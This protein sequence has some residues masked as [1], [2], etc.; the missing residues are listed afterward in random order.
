MG[1]SN[2][3]ALLWFACI[4]LIPWQNRRMPTAR[5]L[6]REQMN[7]RILELG[8]RQ[9]AEVGAASLSVRA[10]TRE[11]GVSSS[12]VYRYVANRDEL[13]TRLIVDAFDSLGEAVELAATGR[14][15]PLTR[16]R[17]CCTA[18][19]TWAEQ[20]P[21]RWTLIYGSPVPGYRAPADTLAPAGR[22]AR[23]AAALLVEAG[24]TPGRPSARPARRLLANLDQSAA[25]FDS[26]LDG[27]AM[28]ALITALTHLV[29]T[30]SLELSGHLIGTAEPAE[31]YWSW[32][33]DELA[34]DLGLA[35]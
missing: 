4:A 12:A 21:H 6:A 20:N 11:L 10:L 19:R 16:W 18:M 27:T 28:L 8:R 30:L 35:D 3:R 31:A 2:A 15:R 1:S 34:H 17:R 32:L 7:E 24:A 29:G 13:L 14:G 5:D 9:L 23:V 33:V 22:V 26:E 25:L